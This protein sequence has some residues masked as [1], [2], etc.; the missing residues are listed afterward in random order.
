[1]VLMALKKNYICYL[2]LGYSVPVDATANIMALDTVAE[3]TT[4][5]NDIVKKSTNSRGEGIRRR[6]TL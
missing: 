1:M 6:S 4:A 2:F 3:Q 5:F